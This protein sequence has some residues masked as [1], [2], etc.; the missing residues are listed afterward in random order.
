M[1]HLDP[2]LKWAGGKRWLVNI[3]KAVYEPYRERRLVEPFTGGMAVALGLMPRN[4]LLSDI[5]PHLI[6]FYEQ[7][8]NGLV[9]SELVSKFMDAAPDAR[10]K[11]FYEARERFNHPLKEDDKRLA[12]EL[13]YYLNRTCFNGLCRF[14]NKGEFNVPFGRYKTINYIRDFTPYKE[15]FSSLNWE[16]RVGS[17]ESIKVNETDFV[18]ADPPYH[19]EFTKYAKEDFNLA[20]QGELAQ[21]LSDLDIPVVASNQATEEMKALYEGLG[22]QVRALPAPRRISCTG[23][24]TPAE[25]MLAMKNIDFAVINKVEALIES[26]RRR[27]INKSGESLFASIT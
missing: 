14:N 22:F 2:P 23:D 16:F 15:L 13:F 20:H 3:L 19:V 7:L 10:E 6:N 18:Y 26:L 5:N 24:R 1:P 9:I 11:Y 25:E 4:A 8:K 21:W 17:Y 12:A 27:A